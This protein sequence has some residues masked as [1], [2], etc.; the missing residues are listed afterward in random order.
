VK[1]A[2]GLQV[3]FVF[4]ESRAGGRRCGV[5]GSVW[6]GL[7]RARS[8]SGG[9]IARTLRFT[10]RFTLLKARLDFCHRFRG[11][12]AYKRLTATAVWQRSLTLDG[13]AAAESPASPGFGRARQGGAFFARLTPLH[14][15]CLRTAGS[16]RTHGRPRFSRNVCAGLTTP[17]AWPRSLE[18]PG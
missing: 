11:R 4:P 5:S 14:S 1:P 18:S 15:S 9:T 17:F 10:E 7:D 8:L 3:A 2:G 12:P 16:A 6:T 13:L